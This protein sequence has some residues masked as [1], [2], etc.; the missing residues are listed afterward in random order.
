MGGEG[1][2]LETCKTLARTWEIESQVSFPGAL[3]HEQVLELFSHACGFVQHSVMPTYGD[4]EGTPVAILEAGAAALPVVSTHH[5]GIPGA[6]I[7]GRTGF[8]VDERN[9]DGMAKFMK[10]LLDEIID[11]LEFDT[12]YTAERLLPEF[13]KILDAFERRIAGKAIAILVGQKRLPLVYDGKNS[14]NHCRYKR[15]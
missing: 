5:A 15:R 4:A 10:M 13:W 12:L 14:A 7:H 1:E 3:H 8:L 2:L 9:V 11:E 6:V